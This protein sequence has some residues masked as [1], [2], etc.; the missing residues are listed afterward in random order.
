MSARMVC[1]G[2]SRKEQFWLKQEQHGV[3]T[4]WAS[5]LC[6]PARLSTGSLKLGDSSKL[7]DTMCEKTNPSSLF[8]EELVN[9]SGEMGAWAPGPSVLLK[10]LLPTICL[11][12]MQRTK[13][14]LSLSLLLTAEGE[15]PGKRAS[16]GKRGAEGAARQTR[17]VGLVGGQHPSDFRTWAR[18]LW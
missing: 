2:H 14:Q 8:S 12:E 1:C 11:K 13:L 9:L 10:N 7:E 4:A 15:A 16:I 3:V 5:L 6:R 17:A 18:G